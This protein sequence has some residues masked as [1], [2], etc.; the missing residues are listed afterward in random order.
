V[1]GL[2]AAT[3]CWLRWSPSGAKVRREISAGELPAVHLRHSA[4][5]ARTDLDAYPEARREGR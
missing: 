5:V 1:Q 3:G 2:G 4:R